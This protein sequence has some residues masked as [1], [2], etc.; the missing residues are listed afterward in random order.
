MN[1]E[2]KNIKRET[3][4]N[5]RMKRK[6]YP[7]E[8]PSLMGQAH[9]TRA[10]ES[11]CD[12]GRIHSYERRI[13]FAKLNPLSART[14]C[15]H[16]AGPQARRRRIVTFPFHLDRTKDPFFCSHGSHKP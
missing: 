7:R 10:P 3:K 8:Y 6:K 14:S 5:K 9:P 16:C 11:L 2:N 12:A 13:G 4:N 15:A 1:I